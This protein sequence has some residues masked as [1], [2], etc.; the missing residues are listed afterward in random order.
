MKS[1]INSIVLKFF[2]IVGLSLILNPLLYAQP[3]AI[4]IK[5]NLELNIDT[6]DILN[7]IKQGG[8]SSNSNPSYAYEKLNL[9]LKY[10]EKNKFYLGEAIAYTKL[11]KLYFGSN[12]NKSIDYFNRSLKI[13]EKHKIGEFDNLAETILYLAET[14][15]ESG[16]QD[17]SAYYF[18]TLDR[19]IDVDKL[20]DPNLAIQLYIKLAVFWINLDYTNTKTDYASVLKRYVD[21]SVIAA[22][23]LPDTMDQRTS[24]Y[25]I[26]GVYHHGLRNFDSA[27]YYYINYLDSRQKLNKLNAQ[28]Q[29]STLVNI[30]ETYL[31]DNNPDKAIEYVDKAKAVLGKFSGNPFVKFF[32]SFIELHRGKALH[33]KNEYL[34]SNI[35]FEH[36]LKG[37]N[38]TG[39]HLRVEIVDAYKNMAENYEKM[40]DFQKALALKNQ[41]IILHDSLHRKDRV[42][43]INRLEVRFKLTEKDKELAEKQLMVNESINKVKQRNLILISI[44]LLILAAATV[45]SL[46][47]RKNIDKQRLQEERILNL[48]NAMQIERLN[49]SIAGEEKERTRIAQDLHD[50]LGGLLAAAKLQIEHAIKT[51]EK[52]SISMS[53]VQD[54]LKLLQEAASGLRDTAH[55][56]MPN[57]LLTEGLKKA[58]ETYCERM[59][60]KGSTQINFQGIGN[61]SNIDKTLEVHIYRII[62][63]LVHNIKK[64][65]KA[66][67][68][69]VQIQSNE[70]GSVHLT[71]EDDGI[72]MDVL[73]W[74]RS[75]NGMG[76][77]S[78]RQR[79]HDLRGTIE[80]ES[81]PNQGTSVY[82]DFVQNH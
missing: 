23:M 78:I 4:N 24:P 26:K 34:A 20:S 3:P 79:V 6:A 47:R 18:Y 75:S 81:F 5:T 29:V 30:A 17:S 15:D 69:L 13:Y 19:E 46:W 42:D 76:L 67:T 77:G 55:N 73:Q 37:L 56:L 63:E 64:H 52:P 61:F 49:A 22:Q 25:F 59:S 48:Q 80:F 35:S 28:R 70:D 72:G 57:I 65:A 1:V 16:R 62:Q 40:G 11:A 60:A 31:L 58:L 32:N 71:I 74:H 39:D 82:I 66:R 12:T 44:V 50:G 9:A 14:Y 41:Y 8:D 45:F 7:I 10:A 2:Y 54:G 38:E 33:M 36:A 43:M 27:R 68:A 21:K 53:E 51:A